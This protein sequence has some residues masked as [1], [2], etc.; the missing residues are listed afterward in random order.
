MSFCHNCGRKM[1]AA[2][3]FC[4]QCGTPA[5]PAPVTPEPMPA[6]TEA[7]TPVADYVP[8]S[9]PER[10]A[11][12]ATEGSFFS[13]PGGLE[14]QLPE[15]A[16]VSVQ[17]APVAQSVQQTP[18]QYFTVPADLG[19]PVPQAAPVHTP[20]PAASAYT[21]PAVTGAVTAPAAV[22]PVTAPAKKKK[23]TGRSH[24]KLLKFCKVA[25]LWLVILVTLAG[26]G[27]S[28]FLSL[29][30]TAV[31][32]R[33][34]GGKT[35]ATDGVLQVSLQYGDGALLFE[36]ADTARMALVLTNTSQDIIR[37]LTLDLT[38]PD[39]LRYIGTAEQIYVEVLSPGASHTVSLPVERAPAIDR[40]FVHSLLILVA[41]ALAVVA[42]LI[43]FAKLC[44]TYSRVLNPA[45]ACV[46]CVAILLPYMVPI[47]EAARMKDTLMYEEGSD[48]PTAIASVRSSEDEFKLSSKGNARLSYE[49]E[50]LCEQHM[51]LDATLSEDQQTLTL[52]WNTVTGAEQYLVY[53]A[54]DD[55]VFY[56]VGSTET[57]EFSLPA[58]YSECIHYYRVVAQT[59]LG[60]LYSQDLRVIASYQGQLYADNDDDLLSNTL[61]DAF[62]TSTILEDTD[63]DGLSDYDEVAITMTD[64]LVYDSDGNGISDGQEDPDG[65]GLTNQEERELGTAPLNPDSDSD[66]LNDKEELDTF[67]SDPLQPDTDGDG[68]NDGTE[69]QLGT[70]PNN[71]DTDADGVA[72]GDATYTA[73]FTDEK[74]GSKLHA[75]QTGDNLT[76]VDI[77]DLTDDTV[78]SDED[79]IAS[80]VI[81][82]EVTDETDGTLDLPI[83]NKDGAGEVIV[84]VYNEEGGDFR[85]VDGSQ[86]NEDGTSISVP[87]S[88]EYFTESQKIT[89]EGEKVTTRK[90]TY[91]AFYVAN[92]HERFGAPLSPD[93]Q[94]NALFDVSFV[95][96]ESGSMED[97]SKGDASDPNRYRVEAAKRF[98][99]ALLSGDRAAVVGFTSE[100]NRK[101]MLSEDM[102]EVRAAIDTIAGTSGGTSVY[103]GLRE[104]LDELIAVE[105]DARGGFIILLTDG[106]DG[107]SNT[108]AYDEIIEECVQHDIPIFAIG[109]GANVNTALLTKLASYTNGAYIPIRTAKD[110]PQVF[111]RIENTAFFGED[112]DGDGLADSVETHGLRDGKGRVY[113]TDPAL[114]FTDNDDL[115]DGEEAGNVMY[116]EEDENGQTLAYY[117]MVTD[118][119]SGDTD[120]DGVDD[121]DELAMKT[122]PWCR[123]TDA[124]GLSDGEELRLGYDP[125]D[126]NPDGDCYSDYE[127][128]FC[129]NWSDMANEIVQMDDDAPE[130]QVLAAIISSICARDPYSY[131]L[132]AAEKGAALLE[133]ALL[134]DFGSM[135]ADYGI[136]SRRYVNSFYYDI[137]GL[138]IDFIPVASA[139][140]GVR[141]AVANAIE[142]KW[143]M[144]IVSLAG[145]L[146]GGKAI[147]D[148]AKLACDVVKKVYKCGSE[149]AEYNSGLTASKLAAAPALSYLL[150][151]VVRNFEQ[152]F[153]IDLNTDDVK[154]MIYDQIDL[155]VQGLTKDNL[156][157][158]EAFLTYGDQT[159]DSD[160][161]SDWA[162]T[163]YT[164][165]DALED[166]EKVQ[167]SVS[168][169]A[170]PIELVNAARSAMGQKAGGT[171]TQTQNGVEYTLLRVMDLESTEYQ[172]EI[173]LKA[174]I[175]E[176]IDRAANYVDVEYPDMSKKLQLMVTDSLVSEDVYYMLREIDNYANSKN[177]ALEY[178]L[179]LTTDD[180]D[181]NS[182]LEDLQT[183][184]K[185][186]AIIIL[187]GIAA[188]ELVAGAD[189]T[190]GMLTTISEG[191]LAWLPEIAAAL[192]EK[193][194]RG[195]LL[196]L[197]NDGVPELLDAL[198][199]L[200]LDND[201]S[202][203]YKIEP[204]T[205][206][207][208]DSSVGAQGTGTA[209]YHAMLNAFGDEQ[210]V[211]FFSY[212]WRKPVATAAADLEKY[213]EARGYESVRFVCHS[214]GGIVCSTYLANSQANRDMTQQVVTIGTPYGG[215]PKAAYV[216][217]TGR[218][219]DLNA[220]VVDY[221][222]MQL[223][224]NLPSVYELLPY[225][226]SIAHSG[227][228]LYDIS[229]QAEADGDKVALKADET[230]QYL[231]NNDFDLNEDMLDAAIQTQQKLYSGGSHIMNDAGIDCTIIAGMQVETV[232]NLYT[233]GEQIAFA[234]ISLAGDGTVPLVSAIESG[235]TLFDNPIY[236]VRGVSHTDLFSDADVIN[237]VE[238]LIKNGD[239]G[240][241]N[242]SKI[243]VPE[244]DFT[245]CA[246]VMAN[247]E[248][249]EEKAPDTR[250]SVAGEIYDIVVA[251]CPVELSLYDANGV[252]MGSVGSDGIRFAQSTDP[253]LFHL[254]AGG[255]TKQVI[256]P[257]GCTVKISG[258]DA[259]TMDV[260]V[261]TANPQGQIMQRT[262]YSDMEVNTQMAVAVQV[263]AEHQPMLHIDIDGDG[264]P[265]R[266]LTMQDGTSES[267]IPMKM[268]AEGTDVRMWVL[269][270]T[271]AGLA[272][273]VALALLIISQV[274][275]PGKQRKA[276]TNKSDRTKE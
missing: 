160:V 78:F 252:W 105:D 132:C 6:A 147:V 27:L 181:Y 128:L 162:F 126:A 217:E 23:K 140:A 144:A 244:E 263:D 20:E 76:V 32:D 201:G 118:P 41:A 97:N 71:A 242:M 214:M 55:R 241:Y 145:L 121:L 206:S 245:T 148:A 228:Y 10:T 74:S 170:F 259:G 208:E 258:E 43:L 112:T 229:Q 113:Y 237:L 3:K 109:L 142:G 185:K 171:V 7:F 93:R 173:T 179:Y 127:E 47:A 87:I 21:V 236:L 59:E 200:Q 16:P 26:I 116:T 225:D 104:A 257:Q 122:K 94:E 95:I 100:A 53:A 150:L 69:K 194:Y 129:S 240:S 224:Q 29:R 167:L 125:T 163:P 13:V 195:M 186:Q 110:L 120:R 9:R 234:G 207:P 249:D 48:V 230:L 70:D 202:S 117:L 62:G 197:G 159:M 60:D 123:D 134:G 232:T 52:Y 246:Q 146:P 175:H 235:G 5:Q 269:I 80:P 106:A 22:V 189:Y 82:V 164:A 50:Y 88:D 38:F 196:E 184:E 19:E 177:V 44:G 151:R 34:S 153:G 68:L 253:S 251:Y 75:T 8:V 204:K 136:L 157:N 64:P 24:P 139:I 154:D 221:A 193:E 143:A 227:G 270:G 233:D 58:P 198:S 256:I 30:P 274:N 83:T 77:T 156:P 98:T 248:V 131:D 191:E 211:V 174:A 91:V 222:F 36:T 103:N 119:T 264:S 273:A 169:T 79:Y 39:D 138:I 57:G 166:A 12:A 66:G 85:E 73:E 172:D 89:D 219:L 141:D 267:F 266:T 135:L 40:H 168:N 212:D 49:A 220:A 203:L 11:A 54:G 190:G 33:S 107:S 182:T 81:T 67:G 149:T 35:T 14:P 102:Y 276:K 265:E 210:D 178:Y 213:I 51:A 152:T 209:M 272:L 25:L 137:G 124:D 275:R 192:F 215:A 84:V 261:A 158:W 86:L 231:K 271:A 56:E 199:M 254:L 2:E 92:W 243:I 218:F 90:S 28:L 101:V 115:P 188:S 187:P 46:L 15:A 42:L 111:N 176:S 226:D 183:S 61:E 65:D 45:V 114:R 31:M 4:A 96:D 268:Q 262:M 108:S 165:G 247:E 133:G 255:E 223:S 260:M 205:V 37:E 63:G 72:D 180:T 161:A 238:N 130:L 1:D 155:G 216:F 18:E 17:P 239:G 99:E 250:D